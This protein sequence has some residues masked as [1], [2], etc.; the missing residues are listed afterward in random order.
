MRQEN[1]SERQEIIPREQRQRTENIGAVYLAAGSS[2]RFGSNKLLYPIKG[3]PMFVHGLRLLSQMRQE[4]VL[5]NLAVVTQYPEIMQYAAS[6][7]L[8]AIMHPNSR[9]GISSSISLG[10]SALAPHTDACLFLVADQPHISKSSLMGLITGWKD[11]EKGIGCLSWKGAMGNPVLFSS[12]YY[13]ELFSL[14]GDTG[15]KKIANAHRED[16]WL[17]EAKEERELMDVDTLSVMG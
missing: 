3:E 9:L 17:F 4:G 16:V 15:G 2:T 13:P 12:R 6:H 11:S 7:D 10:L 8:T 14:T 1:P 5:S